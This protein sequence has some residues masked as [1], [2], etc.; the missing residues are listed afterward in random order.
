MTYNIQQANDDFGERSYAEQLALIEQVGPDILALQELVPSFRE[1]L[2]RELDGRYPYHTLLSDQLTDGQGLFSRYRLTGI[3]RSTDNLI[4]SANVH[5]PQGIISVVN[6]HAPSK[7]SPFSWS[8]DWREQRDFLETILDGISNLQAPV[9]WLGDFNSTY[10]SD[11]Y[12]LIHQSFRDTVEDSGNGF[13]FTYPAQE[14]YGI[15]LI[16]PIVRIDYI[17]HNEYFVSFETR[18]LEDSGG[19]DHRP[20]VAILGHEWNLQPSA[21]PTVG[22]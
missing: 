20:V 8:E 7:F 18:I 2:L 14:K 12:A 16:W 6:V 4:I 22:K 15:K 10:L 1:P 17:F 5:T 11:N 19:S 9:L 13:G 21:I 3:S